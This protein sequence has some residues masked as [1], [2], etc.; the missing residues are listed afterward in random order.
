MKMMTLDLLLLEAMIQMNNTVPQIISTNIDDMANKDFEFA[1]ANM[2][3]IV[4]KGREALEQLV[5]I[6]DQSQQPRAYEV[7]ST[8]IK[9]LIDSNKQ[10]IDIHKLAKEIKTPEMSG[11]TV[12]MQIEGH[13]FFGS[14]TD[15][16]KAIKEVEKMKPIEGEIIEENENESTDNE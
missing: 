6:A 3:D 11:D 14:T 15:L 12:H 8:L 9:T 5:R 2:I 1:R 10:I 16:L 13:A 4:D 7:L